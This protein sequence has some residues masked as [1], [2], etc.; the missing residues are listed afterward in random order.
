MRIRNSTPRHVPQSTESRDLSKCLRAHIHSS[1]F[2]ESQK[3][4]AREMFSDRWMEKQDVLCVVFHVIT[5]V[6]YMALKPDT[7]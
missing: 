1:I 7:C 6:E 5:Y 2:H 4:E 3:V